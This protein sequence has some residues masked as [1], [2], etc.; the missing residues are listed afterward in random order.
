MCTTGMIPDQLFVVINT[1]KKDMY[2]NV[3]YLVFFVTP[4]LGSVYTYYF[5]NDII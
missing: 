5:S 1:D 3:Q 2:T 4:Q